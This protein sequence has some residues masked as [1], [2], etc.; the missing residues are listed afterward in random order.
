MAMTVGY[1]EIVAMLR[2]A[3]RRI[4]EN[5]E[6]LGKLDSVGGD[7]DHGP[8]MLRVMTTLEKAIDTAAASDPKKLLKDAG[9]AVMGVDGGATGPLLGSFL[10]GM[11][12]AT[13]NAALDGP[14][15]AAMFSAGLEKVCKQTRARPG[16]KTMIDALVPAVEAIQ[17]AAV[18][19]AAIQ[20]LM[21]QGAA[22]A[23]NMQWQA[24]EVA[25]IKG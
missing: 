1:E 19:G 23:Y 14:A 18:A 3:C 10:M 20:D 17:A 21:A 12:E 15:L 13:E 24:T 16:D 5:H 11:S 6:L 25:K 7:G 4:K 2:G 8:T 22:A 9:W